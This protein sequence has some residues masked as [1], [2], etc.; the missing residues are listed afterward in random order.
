MGAITGIGTKFNRWDADATSSAGAWVTLSYIN[1]IGGPDAT[2]ETVDVTTLDSV[3][4]YR[5]F[6]G[7]L[8]DAGSISLAM[9][10]VRAGYV[11]MK[12]DFESDVLQNYE[13]VLPDAEATSLEFSGLVTDCPLDIPMDDKVSNDVT[14]KISGKVTV[15]SGAGSASV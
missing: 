8:R 14:I 13:I 9:N 6:I 4:G 1:N 12:D 3:D 2:R 15:N 10:F 5:E 11:L 7:S